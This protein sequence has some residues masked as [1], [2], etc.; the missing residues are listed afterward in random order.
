MTSGDTPSSLAEPARPCS[1]LELNLWD[2]AA[3]QVIVEEAGGRV[4][5]LDG[6]P[7]RH[8]GSIL[9]TNGALHDDILAR[10]AG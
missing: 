9:S 8:G 2:Y 7:P 6:S 5:Q 1:S 3:I 4:T 10:L